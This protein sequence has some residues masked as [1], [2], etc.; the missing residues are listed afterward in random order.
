MAGQGVIGD[1]TYGAHRGSAYTYSANYGWILTAKASGLRSYWR[2]QSYIG[3]AR[4]NY[5]ALTEG[6]KCPTIPRRR[7]IEL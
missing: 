2:L 5:G 7:S 1:K 3:V 6:S 4:Y